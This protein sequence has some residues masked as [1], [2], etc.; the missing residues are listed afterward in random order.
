[1]DTFNSFIWTSECLSRINQRST[2]ITECE[3]FNK[4]LVRCFVVKSPCEGSL[5]VCPSLSLSL[6]MMIMID[7]LCLLPSD[8]QRAYENIVK[9][10]VR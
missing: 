2:I 4:P 1:M 8:L 9:E 6:L 5:S 10:E 3:N 7:D